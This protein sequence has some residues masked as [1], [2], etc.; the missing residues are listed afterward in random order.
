VGKS[1]LKRLLANNT[2]RALKKKAEYSS[3]WKILW[4]MKATPW[5]LY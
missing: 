2:L 4:K 5:I 1:M 3:L